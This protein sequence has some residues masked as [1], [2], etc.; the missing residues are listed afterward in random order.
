MLITQGEVGGL[1]PGACPPR[2]LAGPP[3]AAGPT[4]SCLSLGAAQGNLRLMLPIN[5]NCSPNETGPEPRRI[6][7]KAFLSWVWVQN[8]QQR[9]PPLQHAQRPPWVQ[10]GSRG[11]AQERA[12]RRTPPDQSQPAAWPAGPRDPPPNWSLAGG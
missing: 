8:K 2:A 7:A 1:Q 10:A 6:P 11:Q 9:D 3:W 5:P 12:G 4:L